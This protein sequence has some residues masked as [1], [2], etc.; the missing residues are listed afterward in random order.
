MFCFSLIHLYLQYHDGICQATVPPLLM[1]YLHRNMEAWN[2]AAAGLCLL[3][4]ALRVASCG[5]KNMAAVLIV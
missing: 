3:M 5:Q 1:P 4:P 2:A